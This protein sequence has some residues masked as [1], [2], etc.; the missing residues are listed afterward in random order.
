M[1]K[2]VPQFYE[3]PNWSV[4]EEAY[5]SEK[6]KYPAICLVHEPKTLIWFEIDGTYT[7]VVDNC[8]YNIEE[9]DTVIADLPSGIHRTT[10]S[11]RITSNTELIENNKGVM[12]VVDQNKSVLR[13]TSSEITYYEITSGG[14]IKDNFAKLSDIPKGI[15]TEDNID[16]IIAS[17]LADKSELY[18]IFKNIIQENSV[19]KIYLGDEEFEAA[20]QS[21]VLPAYPTTLPASDTT[22]TYDKDGI[23][24]VSGKAVASAID[25]LSIVSDETTLGRT[26]VKTLTDSDDNQIHPVTVAD[27]VFSGQKKLS[28]ILAETPTQEDIKENYVNKDSINQPN[29]VAGLNDSGLI[30]SSLLP[31]SVDEI[32]EFDSKTLFPTQGEKSKIYV[33]TSTNRTYRW[34]GSQYVEIGNVLP[35]ATPTQDGFM[36]KEQV[37]MLYVDSDTLDTVLSE[38]FQ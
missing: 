17:D 6:I 24:P 14:Y 2:F 18:E 11:Y 26:N 10:Y 16:D 13:I 3:A 7:K 23:K 36:T 28:E 20:Y 22:D 35:A 30:D 27:A 32:L 29:G 8:I 34:S 38:I 25:N 21:I 15:V 37:T 4:F 33:D 19:R 31:G 5:A 1:A 9:I 12:F